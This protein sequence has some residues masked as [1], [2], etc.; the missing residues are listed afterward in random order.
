[1]QFQQSE[2][3]A[4]QRRF[5][6]FLVDATDGLT[7]EIG[8]AGG[9]PQISKN[10][11]AFANTTATL[12]AIANGG[13]YVELTAVELDTLGF[14]MVRFKSANTA[15]FNLTAQV[16]AFDPYD[17]V[18]QGMTALP[19]AA[20][21]AAG[22][23]YTRGTGAGQ[24]NQPANGQIDTNVVAMAAAVLT[25][26]AIAT[27]AITAA[28]IAAGAITVSEAPNLDATVSS[29]A[30]AGD[31]MAL[32]AAAINLIWD[33]LISEARTAGSYGQRVKDAVGLDTLT[34]ARVANLDNPDALTSS[35]ATPAQVNTE[36]N[37]V[38]AV[39]TQTEEAQGLPPLTPT[40][41]QILM[42][43]YMVLRND[44]ASTATERRIKNDA[45]TVI[46]KGTMADDGTTFTQG[47]LAT[48]P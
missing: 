44:S 11:A 8:E 33:E 43:L 3:T 27:D 40:L 29:R 36:V 2:A 22:G 47:K 4:T 7:P 42:Y 20:A 19:N 45:G 24:I 38:L 35:R 48:G 39:D 21:E 1:M 10:G 18:R 46:A 12:T 31:S 41:K 9:Q 16:V 37:D 15:E 23:L 5:P 28:K 6:L 30:I 34:A 14:I 13:Y 32:T 17:S 25:A 26:A